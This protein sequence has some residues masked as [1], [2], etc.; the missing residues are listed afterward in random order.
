MFYGGDGFLFS[1]ASSGV[2]IFK[3]VMFIPL[4]LAINNPLKWSNK[5]LTIRN[6]L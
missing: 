4:N 6:P 3:I 5:N 1:H 2:T